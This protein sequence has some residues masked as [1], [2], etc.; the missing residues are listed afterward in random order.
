MCGRKSLTKSEKAI[1]EELLVDEWQVEDYAPSYNIAPTQNS[2]V[3]TQEKGSNIIKNM[4]WG[5]IP[6]WSKDESSGSKMINARFETITTKPSFK[7]LIYQNRCVVLCDG[8]YEWKQDGINKS[9]YFIQ[10]KDRTLI[11]LAGLWTVWKSSSNYVFTYTILTTN[12]QED[13]AHIHNRMPVVLN[14]PKMEMWINLD[15]DYFEIKKELACFEHELDHHQVSNFVNSP[16]NNSRKCIA[17]F[18]TPSNLNLFD[19][20]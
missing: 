10:R 19:N 6:K 3:M 7:N 14:K 18:K 5:L 20:K 2:L 15:N 16:S 13:I 9:P 1:I 17:P 8:Y 11:L 12:P 4:K